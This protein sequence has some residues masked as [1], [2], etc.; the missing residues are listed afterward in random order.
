MTNAAI[1]W[2]RDDLR[3]SDH[4]ALHAAVT[5]GRPIVPVYVLDD[6]SP[7]P[8][9]MGAATRWWLHHSLEAL[10]DTLAKRGASLIIL[11]GD[12]VEIILDLVR[13]TN[14]GAV[15]WNRHVEPHWQAA[16]RRLIPRS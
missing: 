10:R 14:A 7:G 13:E 3:M 9:R 2:F 11:R 12:A 15:Y 1:V 6:C 16:D 8:R 5:E 4:P